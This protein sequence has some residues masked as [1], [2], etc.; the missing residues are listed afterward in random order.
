MHYII[1]RS[2]FARAMI[3]ASFCGDGNSHVLISPTRR[4][5]FPTDPFPHCPHY[6]SPG[7]IAPGLTHMN[8]AR[9]YKKWPTSPTTVHRPCSLPL[10]PLI[11]QASC[12]SEQP[13]LEHK[14]N[15]NV[16]YTRVGCCPGFK[17]QKVQSIPVLR[18]PSNINS[19]FFSLVESFPLAVSW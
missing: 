3:L 10:P 6:L 16:F 17:N 1:L 18:T 9:T 15:E 19:C 2:R 12:R 13:K 4:P 8:N 7:S 14:N 5:E 11:P